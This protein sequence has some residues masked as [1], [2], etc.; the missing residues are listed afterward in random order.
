KGHGRFSTMIRT[1]PYL[2]T[3][4]TE[5]VSPCN[6]TPVAESDTQ[7]PGTVELL[8]ER[9]CE[10]AQRAIPRHRLDGE[11]HRH[12]EHLHGAVR[13]EHFRLELGHSHAPCVTK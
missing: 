2:R 1:R 4:S 10:A 12:R 13:P 9:N 7:P 8:L 5:R 11:T 3:R 6:V